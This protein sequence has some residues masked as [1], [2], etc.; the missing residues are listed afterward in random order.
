MNQGTTTTIETSLYLRKNW[1]LPGYDLTYSGKAP[2][3]Q[4]VISEIAS[5]ILKE[6]LPELVSGTPPNILLNFKGRTP[7]DI[8]ITTTPT[9][10]EHELCQIY[11]EAASTGE[12]EEL[13]WEPFSIS[14]LTR[15][16]EFIGFESAK[17]A[18]EINRSKSAPH[19]I[20]L[21]VIADAITLKLH[22]FRFGFEHF[23]P[24]TQKY[25]FGYTPAI[26]EV[27]LLDVIAQEMKFQIRVDGSTR[28]VTDPL[29]EVPQLSLALRAIGNVWNQDLIE[30]FQQKLR[31]N[32]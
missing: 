13:V 8:L 9:P 7:S 2:L 12:D 27:F 11:G 16:Q 23:Q 29:L 14:A 26:Q 18:L 31:P 4:G 28:K 25:F 21:R 1:L 10:S 32:L 30:D 24:T 5:N 15:F 17:Y 6:L 22:T 20:P 19:D 3:S